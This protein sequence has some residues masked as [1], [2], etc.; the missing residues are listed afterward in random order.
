MLEGDDVEG[1][2]T[3]FQILDEARPIVE[4]ALAKN[5]SVSVDEY[6]SFTTRYD[7]LELVASVLMSLEGASQKVPRRFGPEV[8]RAAS[9]IIK[10]QGEPS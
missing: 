6:Y 7:T 8:Y 3:H 2:G 4:D 9:G 5:E 10:S 1:Y